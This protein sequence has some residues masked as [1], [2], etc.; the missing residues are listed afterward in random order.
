MT[1]TSTWRGRYKINHLSERQ[2]RVLLDYAV[3]LLRQ[4]RAM[5]WKEFLETMQTAVVANVAQS[6]NG[7]T[8]VTGD[9][10]RQMLSL[11][12]VAEA[13]QP[14][15]PAVEEA[16]YVLLDA[17]IISR[18]RHD[19][20]VLGPDHLSAAQYDDLLAYVKAG[21]QERGSVARTEFE[22]AVL[23]WVRRQV[24]ARLHSSYAEHLPSFMA[25]CDEI[26]WPA[27]DLAIAVLRFA[28][29][30]FLGDQDGREVYR[31]GLQ[32]N[33]HMLTSAMAR[34]TR[35]TADGMVYTVSVA[36]PHH[37]AAARTT[38]VVHLPS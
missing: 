32:A 1:A 2:R 34:T 18:N 28:G 19:L 17:G 30:I 9:Q 3:Q 25:A 16:L 21:L 33:N 12:Q 27:A 13:A 35:D 8:F 20:V 22:D 26:W 29:I 31:L 5:H 10:L 4:R 7:H 15:R 6:L 14:W 38:E 11:G 37:P 24:Q 23:R 36:Q